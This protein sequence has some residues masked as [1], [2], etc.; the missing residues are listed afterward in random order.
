MSK[1]RKDEI[2]DEMVYDDDRDDEEDADDCDDDED[3]VFEDD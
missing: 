1:Y 2:D 3:D